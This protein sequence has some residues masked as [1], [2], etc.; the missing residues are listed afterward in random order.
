MLGYLLN[1]I[2]TQSNCI[3]LMLGYD[4]QIIY[5]LKKA[6]LYNQLFFLSQTWDSMEFYSKYSNSTGKKKTCLLKEGAMKTEFLLL[7]LK[8]SGS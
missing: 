7:K 4:L 5:F 2:F 6:L 1:N 8:K 3:W